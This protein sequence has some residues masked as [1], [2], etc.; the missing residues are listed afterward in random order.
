[1]DG[2]DNK[3]AEED[4]DAQE[5]NNADFGLGLSAR[6]VG[7]V[8]GV[9]GVGAADDTQDQGDQGGELGDLDDAATAGVGGCALC[10]SCPRRKRPDVAAKSV[11]GDVGV[12]LDVR[13][14]F[15]G[16]GDLGLVFCW[17]QRVFV[18]AYTRFSRPRLAMSRGLR[19][20]EDRMVA[21][22]R[23]VLFVGSLSLAI[24]KPAPARRMRQNMVK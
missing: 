7:G 14:D 9:C 23:S 2:Y 11:H 15:I 6:Q 20:M 1:M 5:N 16:S 17:E 3:A 19:P 12:R 10:D 4:V 22:S 24:L 18:K 21:H 13:G 8:V